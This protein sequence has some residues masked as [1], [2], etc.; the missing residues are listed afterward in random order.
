MGE[1][2]KSFEVGHGGDRVLPE[3]ARC[4]V[5]G[6]RIATEDVLNSLSAETTGGAVCSASFD[7][8]VTKKMAF[9]STKL[10]QSGALYAR[11]P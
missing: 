1:R 11:E 7:Q 4:Q 2:C 10:R 8:I 5:R 6:R 3:I 9:A